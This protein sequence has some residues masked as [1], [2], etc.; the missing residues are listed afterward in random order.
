MFGLTSDIMAET[1]LQKRKDQAKID[2]ECYVGAIFFIM[3]FFL[4]QK[5][6]EPSN[7]FLATIAFPPPQHRSAVPF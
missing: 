5:K 6:E 2:P 7:T 1:Y 3:N 4:A